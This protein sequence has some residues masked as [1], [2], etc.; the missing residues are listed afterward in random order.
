M[1]YIPASS[2]AY[3]VPS[4]TSSPPRNAPQA[5]LSFTSPPPKLPGIQSARNSIGILTI[6][7]PKILDKTE[8]FPNTNTAA[9]DKHKIA[10]GYRFLI[11]LFFKS[12]IAS[13]ARSVS[14]RRSIQPLVIYPAY[15]RS[16]KQSYSLMPLIVTL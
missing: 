10:I 6:S 11:F 5:K 14:Y 8:R 3:V 7:I 15:G 16:T 12:S 4:I 2:T 13:I 9:I 1:Q